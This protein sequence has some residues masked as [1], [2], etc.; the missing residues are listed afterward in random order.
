MKVFP[1]VNYILKLKVSAKNSKEAL[2]ERIKND[3]VVLDVRSEFEYRTLK[4]SNPL[5]IP[6][7]LENAGANTWKLSLIRESNDFPMLGK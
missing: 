4:I 6:N 3:Q 7:Q 2:F 5:H 1:A